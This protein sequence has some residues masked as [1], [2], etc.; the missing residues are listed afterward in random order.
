MQRYGISYTLL[1]FI[2]LNT[3][4]LTIHQGKIL[5][6]R[7][8]ALGTV[9]GH[10]RDEQ[11]SY[12]P[13]K[14]PNAPMDSIALANHV[15]DAKGD[16]VNRT[17]VEAIG[18]IDI[19]NTTNAAQTYFINSS[20]CV[21]STGMCLMRN[22]SIEL[23]P[24]GYITIKR[25]VTADFQFPATGEYQTQFTTS[26]TREQGTTHFATYAIGTTTIS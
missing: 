26:I 6:A 20:F 25:M 1:F 12:R 23:D 22:L 16:T 18:E 24:N 19:E 14:I 8:W 7:E 9:I 17:P 21:G 10:Y 4:G 5:S 13:A 2:C 3:F 15:Y 11:S